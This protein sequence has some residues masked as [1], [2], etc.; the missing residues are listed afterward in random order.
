N[1]NRSSYALYLPSDY[2]TSKNFP[3]V[4][5]FD[6]HGRG[7]LPLR[8]Y[9]SLAERYHFEFAGSNDSEN[10][11]DAGT[12]QQIA[13]V[14]MND[15]RQRVNINS[16][17]IYTAGFSGGAK[18]AA[19]AAFNNA[20]VRGIIACSTPFAE[21]LSV[22]ANKPDVFLLVG[23]ED[24]NMGGMVQAENALEAAGFSHHL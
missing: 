3:V 20:F 17:L 24:F 18:V 19:T 1:N 12:H 11:I 9:Q 13:S 5:F 21:Q 16:Q 7:K 14:M 22:V 10:G 8:K 23:N 15:A 2:D 6:S 4:F